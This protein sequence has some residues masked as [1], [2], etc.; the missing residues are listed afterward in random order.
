MEL[1]N[2]YYS[3]SNKFPEKTKEYFS[4]FYFSWKYNWILI[5]I[6]YYPIQ[7]IEIQ[8]EKT[9]NYFPCDILEYFLF[10]VCISHFLN[11]DFIGAEPCCLDWF[12]P[13]PLCCFGGLLIKFVF[14]NGCSS[15][16]GIFCAMSFSISRRKSRSSWSQNEYATPRAPARPVRP[17]RCTYV[18]EIFGIS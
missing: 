5:T 14:G 8:R 13:L 16:T 10:S 4:S 18:S 11:P 6:V 3:Q 2:I 12:C 9:L 17:I 1:R 7:N 15:I